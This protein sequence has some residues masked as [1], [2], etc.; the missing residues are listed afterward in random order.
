MTMK[1]THGEMNEDQQKLLRKMRV[2][3]DGI[4]WQIENS[5]SDLA[6]LIVTMN[7][8]AREARR[9]A[10]FAKQA[11]QHDAS[12]PEKYEYADDERFDYDD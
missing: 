7:E 9:I 11:L 10:G 1:R 4:A 6:K 2:D 3:A 8:Q 5:L 12:S